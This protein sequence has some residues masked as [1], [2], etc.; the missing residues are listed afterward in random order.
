LKKAS[1]KLEPKVRVVSSKA[2]PKAAMYVVLKEL[3]RVIQGVCLKS[4]LT[5]ACAFWQG[6]FKV[7]SWAVKGG[8]GKMIT[9]VTLGGVLACTSSRVARKPLSHD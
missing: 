5:E 7:S 2:V 8:L 4:G 9:Y 3:V 6:S 1:K